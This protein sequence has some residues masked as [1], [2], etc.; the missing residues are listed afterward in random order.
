MRS[1]TSVGDGQ[2]GR[3]VA[4]HLGGLVERV[5]APAR[6]S[7]LVAVLQQSQ[8]DARPIPLPAPVMSAILVGELIE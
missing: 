7:D 8:G 1:L 6:E 5:L 4:G 3:V 2:A